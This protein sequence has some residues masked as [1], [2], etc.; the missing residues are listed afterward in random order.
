MRKAFTLIELLVVIAI[1]AILA[2]I[3]IPQFSKYKEAAYRA[4]VRSDVKNA[5]SAVEAFVADFGDMPNLPVTCGP[6][7]TSCDLTDGSNTITGAINVSR[8]DNVTIE[9]NSACPNGYRVI[10]TS[11]YVPNWSASYDSCNGTYTG[12]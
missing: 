2:A 12:F 3:A 1:I 11:E 9:A 8:G 4:A 6:G 10:G 7:P 5:V